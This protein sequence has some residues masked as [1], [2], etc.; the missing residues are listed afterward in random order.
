MILIKKLWFPLVTIAI[1]ASIILGYSKYSERERLKQELNLDGIFINVKGVK[2]ST[3][4]TNYFES[5]PYKRIKIEI[6]SLSSE[7]DD[8]T[9]GSSNDKEIP[10]QII[11]RE[12]FDKSF[13]EWLKSIYDNKIAKK[14]TK[15]IEI[16][17]RD[18]KII[19][20]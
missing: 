5:K 11:D 8:K 20:D 17:Y 19:D 3:E 13:I 18:I 1:F 4:E 16:W 12:K 10:N 6:P 14:Y 9:T 7:L 15:R 2:I